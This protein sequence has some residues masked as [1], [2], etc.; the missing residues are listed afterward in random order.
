[1]SERDQ[2]FGSYSFEASTHTA[3]RI[4]FTLIM[5]RANDRALVKYGR[6]HVPGEEYMT[7]AQ[8]IAHLG[9]MTVAGLGDGLVENPSWML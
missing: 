3:I 6:Q 9:A 8:V 2:V 5:P 7:D 4:S 1:M